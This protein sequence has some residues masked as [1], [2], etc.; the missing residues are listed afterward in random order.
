MYITKKKCKYLF[1]TGPY[2]SLINKLKLILKNI[3]MNILYKKLFCR[4][5]N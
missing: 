3:L 1:Y 5:I 2:L 4:N